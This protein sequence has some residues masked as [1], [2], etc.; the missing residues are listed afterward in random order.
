MPIGPIACRSGGST[1]Y[2]Y[3]AHDSPRGYLKQATGIHRGTPPVRAA[4]LLGPLISPRLPTRLLPPPG[5]F[6]NVVLSP[7]ADHLGG[8][9]N[10][11]VTESSPPTL[12]HAFF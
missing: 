2:A 1:S 4:G 5:T 9:A 3:N 6:P 7:R 10:L 11:D 8:D 12:N